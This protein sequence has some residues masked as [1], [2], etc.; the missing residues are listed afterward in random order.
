MSSP[1]G[2]HPAG[3]CRR[4]VGIGLDSFSVSQACATIF[5]SLSVLIRSIISTPRFARVV[6]RHF[7]SRNRHGHIAEHAN[8]AAQGG[9]LERPQR[10]GRHLSPGFGTFAYESTRQGIMWKKLVG[11]KWAPAIAKFFFSFVSI[12]FGVWVIYSSIMGL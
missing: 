8:P 3:A 1:R 2:R 5:H 9:F 7:A 4:S 11:E 10:R 12:A 6:L